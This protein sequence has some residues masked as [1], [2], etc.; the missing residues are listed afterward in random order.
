[1]QWRLVA[2]DTLI[3]LAYLLVSNMVSHLSLQSSAVKQVLDIPLLFLHVILSAGVCCFKHGSNSKLMIGYPSV[4]ALNICGIW[5]CTTFD[6]CM[7][8]LLWNIN[9]NLCVWSVEL[10]HSWWTW[11]RILF[12]SWRLIGHGTTETVSFCCHILSCILHCFC[13]DT[14]GLGRTGTLIA[15][16]IMKHYKF[17]AAEAIAWIRICRPGSI[18]GPQQEFLVEC[19]YSDGGSGFLSVNSR[20]LV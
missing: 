1:V 3:V 16:F 13:H 6:Q 20:L 5:N 9:G 18:I 4:W 10:S 14:A 2:L 7:G 12:N 17:T 15:C 19:V 8:H 11:S